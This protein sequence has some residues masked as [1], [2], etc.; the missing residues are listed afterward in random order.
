MT[1]KQ[2]TSSKRS[3][4]SSETSLI[5]KVLS[6]VRGFSTN[7]WMLILAASVLGSI[8]LYFAYR[9]Y[10]IVQDRK[11]FERAEV[12]VDQLYA[13]I[14]QTIGEPTK[15]TKNKS[16]SYASAKFSKGRRGCWVGY[17]LEYTVS[18]NDSANAIRAKVNSLY[19]TKN[20]VSII[21]ER[22]PSFA[23]TVDTVPGNEPA[24]TLVDSSGL[25]YASRL[26]Y[27]DPNNI[28]NKDITGYVVT[29]SIGHGG[30]AQAEYYP[31]RD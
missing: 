20:L 1:K 15:N 12:V 4:K 11:Q 5:Q 13:G 28:F 24:Y 17:K 2:K 6:K 23:P 27:Y 31:V 9:Q 7:T 25:E 18:G 14:V 21:Y 10:A 30:N 16:C 26:E 22:D 8:G 19:K 3:T 29:L